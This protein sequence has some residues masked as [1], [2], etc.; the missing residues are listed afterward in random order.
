MAV[1]SE[2]AIQTRIRLLRQNHRI[3]NGD[4]CG[5]AHHR[6]RRNAEKLPGS[7]HG[8]SR[9]SGALRRSELA[10]LTAISNRK[11]WIMRRSGYHTSLAS[12]FYAMSV[13]HRLGLRRI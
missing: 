12:E 4:V 10:L 3:V 9:G 5:P 1:L 11:D 2:K 6:D 13:L 7:E 8:S